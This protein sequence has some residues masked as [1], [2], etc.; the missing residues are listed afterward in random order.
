MLLLRIFAC[1]VI[2]WLAATDQSIASDDLKYI[3]SITF[4]GHTADPAHSVNLQGWTIGF[5]ARRPFAEYSEHDAARFE[6]RQF[7]DREDEMSSVHVDEAVGELPPLLRAIAGRSRA[8][9][10]ADAH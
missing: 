5:G 9:I 3:K 8:R 6:L 4:A 10:V 7:E 2:G 1:A